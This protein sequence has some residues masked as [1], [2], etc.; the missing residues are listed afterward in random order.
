MRKRAGTIVLKTLATSGC[1][2]TLVLRTIN[3][4]VGSIFLFYKT[5]ECKRLV[6][7]V[8]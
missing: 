6:F 2:K 7:A 4:L 1:K 8:P 3:K 5:E